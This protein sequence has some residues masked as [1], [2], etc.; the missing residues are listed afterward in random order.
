[1]DFIICLFRLLVIYTIN[2]YLMI[3]SNIRDIR[4]KNWVKIRHCNILYY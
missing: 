1:M 3:N 2:Y 4:N